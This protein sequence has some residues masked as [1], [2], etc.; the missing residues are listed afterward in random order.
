MVR[1]KGHPCFSL[2]TIVLISCLFTAP[3]FAFEWGSACTSCCIGPRVGLEKNEGKPI[4]SNEWIYFIGA[5]VPYVGVLIVAFA[6]W[7]IGGDNGFKGFLASCCIGPRV[8][9]Q[10]HERKIRSA[11]WLMVIPVIG[12]IPRAMVAL[13]AGQGKTMKEIEKEENL[14]K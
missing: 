12:L 3:V 4:E 2:I 11:E 13:E 1:T 7:D 8:G 5:F 9:E 14:K 10:L 6:A